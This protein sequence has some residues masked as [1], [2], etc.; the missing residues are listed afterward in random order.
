MRTVA[1]VASPDLSVV[2]YVL[3]ETV[4]AGGPVATHEPR[5]STRVV[6]RDH[7]D[8]RLVERWVSG[9]ADAMAELYRR[10]SPALHAYALRIGG[11]ADAADV[12]QDTMIHASARIGQ[13]RDPASLRPWLFAIAR[14]Q[15]YSRMRGRAR[16]R[17][18]DDIGMIADLAL[19]PADHA[20]QAD[21]Q[22]MLWDAADGLAARD[23]RL[24]ELCVRDGLTGAELAAAIGVHVGHLYVMI[25]RMRAR[26]GRSMMAL[27][28][29]RRRRRHCAE[30]ARI[31][32]PRTSFSPQVR[33]RIERHLVKCDGCRPLRGLM[34]RDVLAD[35]SLAG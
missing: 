19:D 7:S 17:S 14:S 29:A 23:R 27:L 33:K 9:D 18:A 26:L 6:E 1:G 35:I 10:H 12:V 28:V 2:P 3:A 20:V 31:S 25:H 8:A 13:L 22:R 15:I 5:W 24:F 11:V 16:C 32:D 34:E 4:S 21:Q 30:L